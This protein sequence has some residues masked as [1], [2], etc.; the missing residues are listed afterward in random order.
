MIGKPHNFVNFQPMPL[1][2][3]AFLKDIHDIHQPC[4]AQVSS[5]PFLFQFQRLISSGLEPEQMV[6]NGVI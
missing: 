3:H 1:Q 5:N 4:S 2:K 6:F